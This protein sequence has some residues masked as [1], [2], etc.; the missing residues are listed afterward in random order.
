MIAATARQSAKK[1][2]STEPNALHE[3]QGGRDRRQFRRHDL[4]QQGI[5]VER[6]DGSSRRTGALLGRLMDISAGGVRV[7]AE[8]AGAGNLRPEHQVR[9]RLEL[10][11]YAG[12][13]PFIDTRGEQPQPTRQWVG[14]MT[15]ARVQPVEGDARKVD[16]AG[17]LVDM[18][19]IDRGMLGLYLSTQPLAA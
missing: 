9:V 13:C 3:S 4:E 19:E 17:R 10:P 1:S 7:R 14:W 18:E 2:A 12:I 11:A 15:V 5:A 8:A 16:V 6:C